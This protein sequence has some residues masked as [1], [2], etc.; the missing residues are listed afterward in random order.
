MT[1]T[2]ETIRYQ[3]EHLSSVMNENKDFLIELDSAIGDGDLGLT[4][5]A[6]FAAVVESMNKAAETDIG[7][8]L[9][10][11]GMAMNNAAPS[12]MGT[13]IASALLRMAQATKGKKAINDVEYVE[14]CKAAVAGIQDRGKADVGDKTILDALVPATRA[15]EEAVE[16][17]ASLQDSLENAASAAE[18]GFDRTSTLVSKHGRGHYYGEKSK[19]H[20]DP[21]AAVGMLIFKGLRDSL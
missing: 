5:S 18:E 17:G 9:M 15:L 12:T 13:L 8:A 2:F 20:K 14:M 21:G 1:I 6:G 19:G 3:F 16:S 4:M 11:A 10:Q 7:R